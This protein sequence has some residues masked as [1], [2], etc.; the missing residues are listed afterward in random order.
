MQECYVMISTTADGVE[1]EITREGKME[2]FP[3]AAT[4]VY[5]EENALVKFS[6]H[7]DKATITR[8]GDY[9]M[10]LDLEKGKTTLGSLGIGGSVG[11]VGT[12]AY[13]IAYRITEDFFVAS[14]HYDLLI[15]EER[16]TMKLRL[17][18]HKK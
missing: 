1:N 4:I 12:H 15:G 6:V 18:S 7:G 11:E 5:R 3:R 17:L 16:Q 14:L 2:L 9:T 10:H 8:E 13:E